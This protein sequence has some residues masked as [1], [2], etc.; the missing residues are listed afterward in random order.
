MAATLDELHPG[1]FWITHRMLG[2]V[3]E[4]EA[5]PGLVVLLRLSAPSS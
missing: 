5:V 3:S 1:T 4:A 2:S